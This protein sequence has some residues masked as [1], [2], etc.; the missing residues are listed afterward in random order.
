MFLGV[1]VGSKL[2]KSFRSIAG[3]R[4]RCEWLTADDRAVTSL[5]DLENNVSVRPRGE[6]LQTLWP[7]SANRVLVM[8]GTA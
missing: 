2:V 7:A 4:F 8:G 1:M 5:W 6:Y 3:S